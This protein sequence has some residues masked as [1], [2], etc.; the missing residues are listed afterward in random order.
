MK[1]ILFASMTILMA[2]LL[3]VSCAAVPTTTS[4]TAA[5]T[6]SATT[7]AATSTTAGT[8]V[9]SNND[10]L[11]GV[12]LGDD[13]GFGPVGY[14][15]KTL[16]E[17]MGTK[18]TESLI[19][20]QM[21]QMNEPWNNMWYET[22]KMLQEKYG[23]NLQFNNADN[24]VTKEA[25]QMASAVDV[26]AAG[27][28]LFYIDPTACVPAIDAAV[29][30]GVPVIPCFPSP[31]SKAT[32]TIGDS[33]VERGKFVAQQILK[34]FEGKQMTCVIANI[35]GQYGIL[36]ERIVGYEEV[37]RAAPNVT[38]LKDSNILEG[39]ADDWTQGTID[40][41]SSNEDVNCII[42]AYGAPAVYC[43]AGVK[44]SGKDIK[45]YGIDAD[46]SMCQKIK[47][48]EITGLFPYDAKSNAYMCLFSMLRVINGDKNVPNFSYAPQYAT[49]W[50][51]KDNVEDYALK[52]FGEKLK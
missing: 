13:F 49:M 51:T 16:V 29:E 6:T 25:A 32:L 44:Q 43:A 24:D 36:D 38:Y 17:R 19:V 28:L 31:E 21:Q 37:L 4:T 48:G 39:S 46:L 8:T 52:Q 26:G 9:N 14:D 22:L 30:A 40:L 12:G 15:M 50:L 42:A 47:D 23:L 3:T 11:V 7:T 33:E 1:K 35:P 5:T 10:D 18:A 34:D 27:I 45:V 2:L 20:V 41:I